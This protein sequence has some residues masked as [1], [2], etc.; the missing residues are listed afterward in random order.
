MFVAS[1]YNA[2][3]KAASGVMAM[4]F[5]EVFSLTLTHNA[6]Q[7]GELQKFVLRSFFLQPFLAK[8]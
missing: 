6:M 5:R 2:V 4:M 1:L 3:H 8:N 7:A